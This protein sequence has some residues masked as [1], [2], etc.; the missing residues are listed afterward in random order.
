MQMKYSQGQWVDATGKRFGQAGFDIKTAKGTYRGPSTRDA[1]SWGALIDTLRY[2][3]TKVNNFETLGAIVGMSNPAGTVPVAPFD[4]LESFFQTGKTWT[5]NLS[6]GGGSDASTYYFSLSNMNSEGIVPNSTFERTTL[7]IAGDTKITKDFKVSG[8][9]TFI[10]SGGTRIQQGSNTSG[11]MLGLLRT[12][13][14]FDNAAGYIF[15]NGTQ[16]T[17]RGGGGYDNPFWTA[18]KSQYKDEVNRLIGA[19]QFDYLITDW[20]SAMYRLG[21]DFYTDRRRTDFRA[22]NL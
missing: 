4:N 8:T 20:F 22:S 18:N 7:K 17:Y 15:P 21:G 16:R 14:S 9:A 2:D 3:P 1:L 12:P 10:S 19:A 5:H 13:P 11:V 6:I